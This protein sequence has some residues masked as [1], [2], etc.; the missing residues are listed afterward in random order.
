MT[1]EKKITSK[2]RQRIPRPSKEKLLD[3]Y[4]NQNLTTRQVATKYEVSQGTALKWL[5]SYKISRRAQ[6]NKPKIPRPPKEMLVALYWNQN[7]TTRGIAAKYKV[8]QET[9]LKWLKS[10]KIS[11]RTP[12]NKQSIPRPPKEMLVA[13]YW[14][15]NLSVLQI[16]GKCN[17]SDGTVLKWLKYYGIP[18]RIARNKSIPPPPK[19]YLMNLYWNQN[20][21]LQ[22]IA[23][24]YYVSKATACKWF[25]YYEAPRRAS[26]S[27]LIPRPPKEKLFDLYWH[28]AHT[29]Q[30]IAT[31]YE[32]SSGTVLNW[33]KEYS[34]QTRPNT[35]NGFWKE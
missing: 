23:E 28:Q 29:L 5:K 25:K 17:V 18:R 1:I 35:P 19:D 26:C 32:V 34:I 31:I 2:L 20:L 3:L 6:A 10:C 30:Q 22:Q 14:N 12:A 21:S 16:A 9:V 15:Q 7:L 13:L 33:F 27:Q 11:R 4:W 24:Q 8:S